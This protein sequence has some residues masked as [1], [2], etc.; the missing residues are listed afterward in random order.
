M[1]AM[2]SIALVSSFLGLASIHNPPLDIM[3][4]QILDSFF[5]LYK[6]GFLC[7]LSCPATCVCDI[8]CSTFSPLQTRSCDT[9]V[10]VTERSQTYS[11][12]TVLTHTLQQKI[13]MAVTYV[14]KTSGLKAKKKIYSVSCRVFWSE[15][16]PSKTEIW[17]MRLLHGNMCL[18]QALARPG[19]GGFTPVVSLLHG[20]HSSPSS[21]IPPLPPPLPLS[22]KSKT[23]PPHSLPGLE[24]TNV[25]T[26]VIAWSTFRL[27][28]L[29]FY[30]VCGRV[31]MCSCIR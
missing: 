25:L 10:S 30:P 9:V 28:A 6:C 21:C 31:C 17:T 29:V 1:C 24:E 27:L 4:T 8:R 26:V 18:H 20:E 12:S 3:R 14:F 7:T 15:A 23:K 11:Q 13:A 16:W 19:G 2:I 22:L 5:F